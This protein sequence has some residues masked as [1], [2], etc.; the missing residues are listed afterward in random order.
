MHQ[1]N[2][3]YSPSEEAIEAKRTARTNVLCTIACVCMFA[4]WG[5]LLAWRG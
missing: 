1:H 2:Y 5:V 3:T 4:G